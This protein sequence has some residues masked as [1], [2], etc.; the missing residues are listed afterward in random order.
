M[1]GEQVDD[2]PKTI[3]VEVKNDMNFKNL[4]KCGGIFKN[5]PEDKTE[6]APQGFGVGTSHYEFLSGESAKK[7][8]K[9]ICYE[10]IEETD[11]EDKQFVNWLVR[12]HAK[13]DK[14]VPSCIWNESDYADGK[15]IRSTSQWQITEGF[16]T[17]Q[18]MIHFYN[19]VYKEKHFDLLKVEGWRHE[20]GALKEP[21][22]AASK[23]G[24]RDEEEKGAEYLSSKLRRLS[25]MSS[26][27]RKDD[28]DDSS[29]NTNEQDPPAE[30]D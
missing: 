12:L 8:K 7:A 14:K 6:L 4:T 30:D 16:S 18:K 13:S 23:K 29:L 10:K 5:N 28:E 11:L 17:E 21:E 19:W 1:A 22:T 15:K 25:E 26:K 3:T 9:I 27:R 24:A 2:E 20:W